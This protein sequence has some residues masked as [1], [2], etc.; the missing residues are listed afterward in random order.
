MLEFSD[1]PAERPQRR[2]RDRFVP[3]VSLIVAGLF[4]CVA[5]TIAAKARE[6]NSNRAVGG[7][8]VAGMLSAKNAETTS[9]PA[10]NERTGLPWLSLPAIP[11]EPSGEPAPVGTKHDRS[12]FEPPALPFRELSRA[13]A[14]AEV[15]IHTW[16]CVV[17]AVAGVSAVAGLIGLFSRWVR[18]P[19]LL[20]AALILL[21]TVG[22]LVAM[23]LLV[24]E[25]AGAFH[26]LPLLSYLLAAAGQ[27]LYGIVLV[28]L[29]AR[30]DRALPGG[31]APDGRG[32]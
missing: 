17:Y 7:L 3:L 13:S 10:I 11:S 32:A 8:L 31:T 30:K 27:S 29:F 5:W 12:A 24:D 21:S 15:I 23:R 4:V 2:R 19:H 6:Y 26:A 1:N 16:E 25:R 22:T 28:A 20:A 14:S 18:G 9:A